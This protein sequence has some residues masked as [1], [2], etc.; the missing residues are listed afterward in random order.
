MGKVSGAPG[1]LGTGS[2]VPPLQHMGA[3]LQN[4]RAVMPANKFAKKIPPLRYKDDGT[5]SGPVAEL[6]FMLPKASMME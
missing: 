6:L 4:A 2:M 5:K 3:P 1:F